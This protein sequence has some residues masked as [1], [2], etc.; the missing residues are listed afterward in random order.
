MRKN[1]PAPLQTSQRKELVF[2]QAKNYSEGAEFCVASHAGLK[3]ESGKWSRDTQL[4]CGGEVGEQHTMPYHGTD[5][6][7]MT[8]HMDH[9]M[10]HQ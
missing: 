7:I 6:H 5:E 3:C 4:E 8:D 2:S 9:T 1:Q 10:P